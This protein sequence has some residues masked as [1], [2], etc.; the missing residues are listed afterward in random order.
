M[1]ENTTQKTDGVAEKHERR[2]IK[3][4]DEVDKIV[5]RVVSHAK[6]LPKK[7]GSIGFRQWEVIMDG[8][9]QPA[10]ATVYKLPPGFYK[11]ERH[12]LTEMI[13]FHQ[14]P[15]ELDEFILFENSTFSRVIEEVDKFWE[16]KEVFEKYKISH[17]RGYLFYGPPGNGKSYLMKYLAMKAVVDLSAVALVMISSRCLH[18]LHEAIPILKVI[19]GSRPLV[20]LLDDLED[21]LENNSHWLLKNLLAFLDGTSHLDHALVLASTNVGPRGLD[22]RIAS[23]PRRFDRMIEISYPDARMRG[24]FLKQKLG[25]EFD[26]RWVELT[27][28]FSLA[29]LSELIV[30]VHC[31]GLD[32]E[33]ARSIIG[34]MVSESSVGIH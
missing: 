22:P 33:Q 17:R 18:L 30:S 31:L 15:I 3:V 26:P 29:A 27:K 11:M 16:K 28:G 32:F 8:I 23:R 10:K 7:E 13:C 2:L 34:D 24:W 12:A 21:L 9:Y 25:D 6:E 1:T 20:F 19:E 5:E 4:G 14:L